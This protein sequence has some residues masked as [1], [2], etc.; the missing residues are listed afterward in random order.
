MLDLLSEWTLLD[1]VFSLL[2]GEGVCQK[3]GTVGHQERKA[4][5]RVVSTPWPSVENAVGTKGSE[6]EHSAEDASKVELTVEPQ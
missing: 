6:M 4:S 1:P 5:T 2:E 3:E